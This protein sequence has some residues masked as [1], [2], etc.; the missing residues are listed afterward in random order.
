M[1]GNG[2]VSIMEF[3]VG[4]SVAVDAYLFNPETFCDSKL[5]AVAT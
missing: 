2:G 5:R 1:L 4:W 3:G